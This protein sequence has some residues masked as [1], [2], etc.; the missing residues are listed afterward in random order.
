MKGIITVLVAAVLIVVLMPVGLGCAKTPSE[1]EASG[2]ME[3]TQQNLDANPKIENG[4]MT[5][6][7][8]T[9]YWDAHGTL[10]GTFVAEYTMVVDQFGKFTM[11][12][13]GT[14]TGKVKG[15][16]GSFVYSIVGSGQF[17]S[18]TGE[19]GWSTS[20]ET[21]I[22]G[23]GDLANLRGSS[24]S[25]YKLDKGAATGTYSGMCRFEK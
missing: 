7:K 12:G 22:S 19:S 13:Q 17:T 18:P 8:N 15:K 24:H 1:F 11:E 5:F 6:E 14:F 20:Y 16:S 3:M 2:T 25:E 4:K 10:E 21:I 9:G 23:T